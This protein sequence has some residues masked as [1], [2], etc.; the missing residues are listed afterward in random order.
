MRKRKRPAHKKAHS[1]HSP[2]SYFP[3]TRFSH[4]PL[5]PFFRMQNLFLTL[6]TFL[7]ISPDLSRNTVL[8]P[9]SIYGI[10]FWEMV[11]QKS[12][13]IYILNS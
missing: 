11:I 8:F 1:S 5:Q 10:C 2:P 6:S 3:T 9:K 4:L 13:N 12:N 7:E